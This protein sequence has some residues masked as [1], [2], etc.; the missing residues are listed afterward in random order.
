M[1]DCQIGL[2]PQTIGVFTSFDGYSCTFDDDRWSLSRNIALNIGLVRHLLSPESFEGLRHTLKFFAVNMSAA[3]TSNLFDRYHALLK[4]SIGEAITPVLVAQY[5]QTLG[6]AHEWYLAAIR[7]LI[8]QWHRLNYSGLDPE[9]VAFFNQLALRGN[10]KGEAVKQ[11]DNEKG[12]LSDI[13]LLGF[14]DTLVQAYETGRVSITELALS[15]LVSHTGS[16]PIQ[17]TNTRLV[18]LADSVSEQGEPFYSILMPRG[19]QPG[20]W[21]RLRFRRRALTEELFTILTAQATYVIATATACWPFKLSEELLKQLPLFPNW[22]A[23]KQISNETE[24]LATIKTDHLHLPSGRVT[25]ILQQVTEA[26]GLISERTGQT[27]KLSAVRFRYTLGTRAAREG[28]GPLVIAEL[29]DHSDT[30]NVGVYIQNVPEHA[31]R[32]DEAVAAQLAPFAQAFAGVIVTSKATAIRRSEPD[33]DI[34]SVS[35]RSAGTCGCFAFCAANVPIPCYTCVH[36]QPWL[37]GP[38]QEVLSELLAERKRLIDVTQ[39]VT[40]ASVLDRSILAV[41][42]VV[43]ACKARKMQ[44]PSSS[45]PGAI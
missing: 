45:D 13:E 39:D 2:A 27:L 28:Y 7:V 44:G 3:H 6:P 10:R 38:H 41:N 19:K 26:I 11:L 8:K 37:D 34:R 30:Q 40:V 18:D 1:N 21:F 31:A 5:R 16:R 25:N 22:S 43:E 20:Q 36:F 14:N 33:S 9:L 42:Q 24:F 4:F 17:I 35:G 12:P 23:I 32:I 29:L 15:M